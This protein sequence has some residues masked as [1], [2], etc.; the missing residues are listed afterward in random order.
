[1][2]IAILLVL[3]ALVAVAWFVVN[4]RH[5]AAAISRVSDLP[6]RTQFVDLAAFRNLVDPAE[7]EYLQEHLSP[8]QFR[9]IQ[10]ERLRAAV[11]YVNG[12]AA[13]A[14]VLVAL[15]QA[16]RIDGDPKVVHAGQELANTALRVRMYAFEARLR[17]YAAIAIP[18]LPPSRPRLSDSYERLTGIVGQLSM[19]Q[20][21]RG[22]VR[23]SA[24][25]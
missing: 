1:M 24:V 3:L 14:A 23:L 4:A 19:L 21:Q 7:R 22:R 5:H 16:A 17:L 20:N 12:V 9:R 2:T 18:S 11:E 10:R 15:G 25:L 8:A 6:G 13:N